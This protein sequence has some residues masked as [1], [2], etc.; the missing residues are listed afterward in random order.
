M[1]T[2]R[3][4]RYYQAAGSEQLGSCRRLPP[5]PRFGFPKIHGKWDWC[6][7]LVP[8]SVGYTDEDESL[9]SLTVPRA[10]FCLQR[11]GLEDLAALLEFLSFHNSP[12][13]LLRI[14]G[15]GRGTDRRIRQWLRDLGGIAAEIAGPD[16]SD[17]YRGQ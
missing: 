15:I 9:T 10:L 3:D 7:E 6:G 2:C 1:P 8:H 14:D 17:A 11:H 12:N 16:P 5:Q 13:S 4:C